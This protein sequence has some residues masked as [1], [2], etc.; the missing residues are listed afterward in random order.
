MMDKEFFDKYYEN[1]KAVLHLLDYI[2]GCAEDPY[3]E[4]TIRRSD[5]DMLFSIS[6]FYYDGVFPK[7]YHY[8]RDDYVMKYIR[9]AISIPSNIEK[10]KKDTRERAINHLLELSAS[11]YLEKGEQ[12][13]TFV[14]LD[15]LQ[16]K[17]TNGKNI[18]TAIEKGFDIERAISE[19]SQVFNINI[20][21]SIIEKYNIGGWSIVLIF[22]T[23]N[24][25]MDIISKSTDIVKNG[26]YEGKSSLQIKESIETL[27]DD[28][29]SYLNRV[30][31]GLIEYEDMEKIFYLQIVNYALSMNH[32]ETA[33]NANIFPDGHLYFIKN[34]QKLNKDVLLDLRR[35][36]MNALDLKRE[37]ML[38]LIAPGTITRAIDL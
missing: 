38:T 12:N 27:K 34:H 26:I 14:L 13:L 24:K 35:T 21:D 5:R 8:S 28:F 19:I 36:I 33:K 32:A 18:D 30:T 37:D 1:E 15:V 16:K 20:P 11:S 17:R 4:G 10:Y 31:N 9:R 23:D 25:E 3:Y 29:V 22:G 6:K 7:A 2:V